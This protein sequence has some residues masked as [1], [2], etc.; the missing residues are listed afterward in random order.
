MESTIMYGHVHIIQMGY[1]WLVTHE[2]DLSTIS[3]HPPTVLLHGLFN[4]HS[5]LIV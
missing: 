5:K 1:I 2:T 4:N 3:V